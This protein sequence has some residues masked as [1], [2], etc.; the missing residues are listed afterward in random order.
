MASFLSPVSLFRFS[1]LTFNAHEFHYNGHWTRSVEGHCEEVVYGLLD[2][3]NILK[4]CGYIHGERVP[5]KISYRASSSM[6]VENMYD[7]KTA[8]ITGLEE[9]KDREIVTQKGD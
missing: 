2:L 3:I 5:K 7:I 8:A 6:Y 9:N 1:A 4:Y